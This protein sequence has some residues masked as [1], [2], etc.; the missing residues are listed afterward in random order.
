MKKGFTL[1]EILVYVGV[2]VIILM[3]VSSFFLWTNRL[4]TKTKVMKETIYNARR[5]M[6]IMTYEIKSA[7]GVYN[8]TS[9][10]SSNEGQLSLQTTR[11]LP[12]G[13]NKTYIDFYVC[14]YRLCLKK[15]DQDPIA[16]TSDNVRVNVLAFH[17]IA[18]T[19]TAPSIQINLKVDYKAPTNKPEHQAS[20]NTTSTASLRSY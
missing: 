9:V 4:N 12:E 2:M 7:E 20:V 15:E 19:S 10:F 6:E 16:L 17:Y 11:Y 18:T 13:E 8:P 3:T 1:I 5:A 14:E